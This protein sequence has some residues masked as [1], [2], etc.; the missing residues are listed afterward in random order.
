MTAI[1][2]RHS[3]VGGRAAHLGRRFLRRGFLPGALFEAA[4]QVT[5]PLQFLLQ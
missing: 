1:G 2:I 4:R 3:A 5:I